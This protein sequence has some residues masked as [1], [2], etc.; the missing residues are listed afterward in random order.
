MKPTV[1]EE[2]VQQRDAILFGEWVRTVPR[3]ENEACA[4]L[5]NPVKVPCQDIHPRMESFVR[6]AEIVHHDEIREE[7]RDLLE[8]A[9]EARAGEWWSATTWNDTQAKDKEEVLSVFD[10]AIRMAK[11]AE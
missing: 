5:R 8:S 3:E 9:I 7:A 4:V 11:E 6:A 1:V 2:L 10:D